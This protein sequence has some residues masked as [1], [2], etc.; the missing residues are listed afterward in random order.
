VQ[1]IA[2]WLNNLPANV[3]GA[4]IPSSS[5]MRWP[6]DLLACDWTRVDIGNC[7]LIGRRAWLS[8]HEMGT[9]SIGDNTAIG[10][11]VIISAAGGISIGKDV[12][13]SY[14][15]SILDHH[16]DVWGSDPPTRSGITRIS[17]VTIEDGVFVGA[18]STILAGVILGARSRVAAGA[19]VTHSVPSGAIV[20][21]IPARLIK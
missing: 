13:I 14:R 12:L 10:R 21:G 1:K 2:H 15:V 9:I 3:R 11:D 6:Y 18:N 16:H 17:P 4:R 7:V 8:T 20:G 19:V 5:A